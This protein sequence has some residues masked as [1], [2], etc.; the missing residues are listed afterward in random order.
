MNVITKN[1]GKFFI[2]LV[3]AS[4]AFCLAG[5][6][7]EL[8]GK[9]AVEKYESIEAVEVFKDEAFSDLV[10]MI[11]IVGEIAEARS[12]DTRLE[13]Y[14]NLQNKQVEID[15]ACDG[16]TGLKDYPKSCE[17]LH[18]QLVKAAENIKNAAEC[19][20]RAGFYNTQENTNSGT[21]EQKEASEYTHSAA[22]AAEKYDDLKE[23]MMKQ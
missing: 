5:C 1:I 10:E 11:D 20:E 8:T 23:E 18:A 4:F 12:T 6:Q 22:D 21:K 14:E 15:R 2:A 19:F 13:L 9:E 16:L 3:V 7:K 17:G